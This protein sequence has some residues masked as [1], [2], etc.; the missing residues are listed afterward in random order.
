MSHDMATKVKQIIP[1]SEIIVKNKNKFKEK[2][3]LNHI[4]SNY[5]NYISNKFLKH[6]KTMLYPAYSKC[7]LNLPRNKAIS[8]NKDFFNFDN[9]KTN[10]INIKLNSLNQSKLKI[11]TNN[12]TN[13]SEDFDRKLNLSM[14][15]KK[16]EK[17]Q[18]LIN[19]KRKL[20]NI[21]YSNH[22][23]ILKRS[24]SYSQFKS[25]IIN[26]R[27]SKNNY[28]SFF[29]RSKSNLNILNFENKNSPLKVK[30]TT[31]I[32]DIKNEINDLKH[33]S[34]KFL[35]ENN[36]SKKSII[37]NKK[38]RDLKIFNDFAISK[39]MDIADIKKQNKSN[40]FDFYYNRNNIKKRKSSYINNIKF[41]K[42][43]PRNIQY[44][45]KNKKIDDLLDKLK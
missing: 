20:R 15:N 12:K 3:K 26:E 41:I 34:N 16:K 30:L 14:L 21:K 13:D 36:K 6:S 37:I 9:F 40:F 31:M 17:K 38:E 2:I 10:T 32:N 8:R 35:T 22:N 5:R 28:D 4:P 18:N 11:I 33:K 42:I 43:F 19:F 29:L 44:Y 24:D 7:H 39:V 1:K 23:N 45:D 25:R 27:I